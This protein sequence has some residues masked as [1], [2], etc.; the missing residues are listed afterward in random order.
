[1]YFIIVS[2]EN[3]C[4]VDIIVSPIQYVYDSVHLRWMYLKRKCFMYCTHAH[5]VPW[6]AYSS[7]F[8]FPVSWTVVF[9]VAAHNSSVSRLRF[10]AHD[11][12]R[13]GSSTFDTS[14]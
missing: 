4:N 12:V 10:I 5:L 11:A 9:F 6:C 7:W 13:L 1:M 2:T 8:P 3:L 14:A